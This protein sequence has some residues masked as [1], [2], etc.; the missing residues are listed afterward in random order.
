MSSL[1]FLHIYAK[2]YAHILWTQYF[3]VHV[4]KMS[5]N[6]WFIEFQLHCDAPTST[7]K[8]EN[9]LEVKAP[10][11]CVAKIFAANFPFSDPP[12]PPLDMNCWNL[13]TQ[14]LRPVSHLPYPSSPITWEKNCNYWVWVEF[15]STALHL[16]I[17][18]SASIF[19]FTVKMDS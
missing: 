14:Q 5:E 13:G 9:I 19:Q 17:L 8:T 6:A 16:S 11:L 7:Y 1:Y 10:S 4:W 3:E 15:H 18:R 2:S 12:P